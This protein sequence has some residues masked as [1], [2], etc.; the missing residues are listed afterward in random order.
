MER[1]PA[2]GL[3]RR[4]FLAQVSVASIA[5][6]GVARNALALTGAPEAAPAGAAIASLAIF[7]A[8]GICRVGNSPEW[9]YAPEIPGVAPSPEGGFK[10]GEQ[11]V[12]KQAQRFRIY[13]LDAEGRVVREVTA[14]TDRVRWTVSIANTKAAWYGF[15][16]PL[17]LGEVAPGLPGAR[18]NQFIADADRERM[19]VIDPGPTS[20]A[21]VNTNPVGADARYRMVGRFW[22]TMDVKLGDLR[23]DDRG[24]LI[25]V[26]GDGVSQSAIPNNPIDNFADND[27]WHDDWAD[28]WV[29]AEVTL[30]DGRSLP[31]E[32]AWV[33]CCGPDF[34]PEI[35]AFITL[36]DVIDDLMVAN[37]I[38]GRRRPE[39]PLSFRRDV[40]PYFR[41]LGLME[42]V[43]A[44]A[45]LRQGWIEIGD[46]LDPA[47]VRRLADPS[48]ANGAFRAHVFRQFRDP[49]SPT[50]QQYRI[51]YMLYDGVNY[52][53][54]PAHWFQIPALQYWL[55]E[56]WAAGNFVNDLDEPASDAVRSFDDIP[57]A[58]QPH[59]LTRAA[60]EPCS[61][62]GFHP[63]VELTWP[64]RQRALYA[65]AFRIALGDRPSLV[66]NVGQ[67]L[68]PE[69]AFRGAGGVPAPIGPQMPGDLTRWMG[70]PWQGDAFSCQQVL[71]ANDFPNAVWWPA[72]LPI[73]VLPEAYYDQVMRTDLSPSERVKFAESRVLWS[74]GVAGI[75]YHAEAAYSTGLSNMVALWHRMG[76]VV[77]R[78]GPTDPGA[79]P[80]IPREM[81]VEVGRGSMSFQTDA[82]PNLGIRAGARLDPPPE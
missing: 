16:N 7:P 29:K 26:P 73:D 37:G 28:G 58:Q 74:R 22:D 18:R 23:T 38:G 44:A 3:T 70:L 69:A 81:F 15:N 67:L 1:P 55:L 64:L 52:D 68:T 39:T 11:L 42:W 40:Y 32:P 10:D 12:K 5:S 63:G 8:I 66:Q 36:Y 33:A 57:L 4:D 71:Y 30:G 76:F 25:V 49:R 72:L 27:G 75:G 56:Q 20:I 41:R 31:V 48:E 78:P 60:L 82:R 14:A 46:F 65:G 43:A 13:A 21:G 51:P 62:G 6:L 77:R 34:A 24:R 45:N 59:A 54:S 17:D 61:G 50:P 9:F 79:P 53:F 35:P 2:S 80:E 19:L 47:Y